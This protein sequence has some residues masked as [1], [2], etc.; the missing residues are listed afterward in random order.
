MF[1]KVRAVHESEVTHLD[2][3]ESESKSG[4]ENDN[5]GNPTQLPILFE[6]SVFSTR[7]RERNVRHFDEHRE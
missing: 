3:C 6:P 1:E 5:H 2:A 7:R 4:A